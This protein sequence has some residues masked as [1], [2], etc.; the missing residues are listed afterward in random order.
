MR[1][2]AVRFVL[3]SVGCKGG[4]YTLAMSVEFN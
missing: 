4:A 3:V 2:I 1:M